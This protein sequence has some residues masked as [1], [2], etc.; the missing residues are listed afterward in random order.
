MK[1]IV[2]CVDCNRKWS[3]MPILWRVCGPWPQNCEARNFNV[4][5]LQN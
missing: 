1:G 3:F 5:E 4:R 2:C